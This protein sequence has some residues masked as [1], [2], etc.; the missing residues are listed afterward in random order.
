MRKRVQ[1]SKGR[2]GVRRKRKREAGGVDR[3]RKFR[4]NENKKEVAYA[5]WNQLESELQKPKSCDKSEDGREPLMERV[6]SQTKIC[7]GGNGANGNDG[8]N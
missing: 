7:T 2:V 5:K 6:E 1:K 8:I 4:S 3:Q